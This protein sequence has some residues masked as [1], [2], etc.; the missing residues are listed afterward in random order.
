VI[1]G[2]EFQP[3]Y[4]TKFTT[5]SVDDSD[6]ILLIIR[7]QVDSAGK[8]VI[9][10]DPLST[11]A[12]GYLAKDNSEKDHLNFFNS[13]N[14]NLANSLNVKN[15]ENRAN[16]ENTLKV[17]N[18]EN[19]TNSEDTNF[20]NFEIPANQSSNSNIAESARYKK[21]FKPPKKWQS[22]AHPGANFT[23]NLSS[24]FFTL[25]DKSSETEVT[26]EGMKNSLDGNFLITGVKDFDG[27]PYAVMHWEILAH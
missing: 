19:H 3:G 21:Y 14:T 25:E 15:Q 22:A 10:E 18:Q 24:D 9:S 8:Y 16:S 23:F 20:A 6:G 2:T 11:S 5:N 27:A 13:E 17:A 26:F 4:E 7:Y 12:P 1:P